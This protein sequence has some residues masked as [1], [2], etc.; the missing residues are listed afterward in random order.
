MPSE[1]TQFKP[2]NNAN[3]AGRPKDSFSILTILKRKLQECPEGEDKKTY[4]ESIVE[5]MLEDAI[6]KGDTQMRKLILNYLEGMPKQSIDVEG[7]GILPIN[8][9]IS[10]QDGR[11]DELQG[12]E[13]EVLLK[14]I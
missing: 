2:N 9:T 6:V 12:G 7:N 11:K 14:A 1:D 10:K 13:G 4:A 3:P 8:I 5:K